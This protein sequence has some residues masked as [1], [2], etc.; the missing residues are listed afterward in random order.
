LTA[1]RISNQ[2][3]DSNVIFSSLVTHAF[4]AQGGGNEVVLQV[5]GDSEGDCRLEFGGVP[6]QVW[7]SVAV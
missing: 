6:A 1:L 4:L 3:F 5:R 2:F 7:D